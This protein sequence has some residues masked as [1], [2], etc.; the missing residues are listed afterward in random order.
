MS[1]S[2]YERLRRTLEAERAQARLIIAGI[3]DHPPPDHA[4]WLPQEWLTAGMADELS[5]AATASGSDSAGRAVALAKLAIAVSEKLGASYPRVTI[6]Q[7]QVHAWIALGNAHRLMKNLQQ[8][9]EALDLADALLATDDVLV[10]E[11]TF[12][13]L[14]RAKTLY[15]LG[16]STEALG[17]LANARSVFEQFGDTVYSGECEQ[18]I[19]KIRR[20]TRHWRPGEEERRVVEQ[21]YSLETPDD[22]RR[23]WAT[24]V[25]LMWSGKPSGAGAML[26]DA[27]QAL[28]RM[29]L[30]AEAAIAGLDLLETHVALHEHREAR[31]LLAQ[32][33]EEFRAPE[34]DERAVAALLY[35]QDLPKL[36]RETVQY[37][38]TYVARLSTQPYTPF[39]LPQTD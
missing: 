26:S 1:E 23:R 2:S 34:W 8:S 4:S 35:L 5:K 36:P 3:A 29:N 13:M 16:L 7:M 39:R 21:A 17:M 27:R 15:E 19:S 9:L 10:Y 20:K 11:E 33:V 25:A 38:R 6:I 14:A 30:H 24:G 32:L 12:V 28:T 31:R 18:L 22:A 37:V